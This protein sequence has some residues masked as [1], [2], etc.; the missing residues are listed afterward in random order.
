MENAVEKPT[1]FFSFVFNTDLES[2]G[3]F[4]NTAQYAIMA[5]VLMVTSTH[6]IQSYVPP[7]DEEKSTL[8][9]SLEVLIQL[10]LTFVGIILIHRVI[11]FIPSISGTP[12]QEI[13]I[14]CIIFPILYLLIMCPTP[15]HEKI[16]GVVHRMTGDSVPKKKEHKS[17]VPSS[18]APIT[19]P[20]PTTMPPKLEEPNFNSMMAGPNMSLDTGAGFEPVPANSFGGSLFA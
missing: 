9:L 2:R 10:V 6:V 1:N 11:T 20:I 5:L 7:F 15:L 14:L 13:N 18:L 4:L 16:Y 8:S 12:Y 19:S 17:H 3:L